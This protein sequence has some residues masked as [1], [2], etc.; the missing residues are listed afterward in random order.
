MSD[1]LLNKELRQ[2]LFLDDDSSDKN[3]PVRYVTRIRTT[4]ILRRLEGDKARQ[5]RILHFLRDAELFGFILNE[6]SARTLPPRE[7]GGS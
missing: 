6:Q 5:E 3:N 7:A 1:L 2:E 4:T